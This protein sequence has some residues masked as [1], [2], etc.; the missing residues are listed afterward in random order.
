MRRQILLK[1]TKQGKELRRFD[2][3]TSLGFELSEGEMSCQKSG[4]GERM[5]VGMIMESLQSTSMWSGPAQ[6]SEGY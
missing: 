3:E 6:R 2:S 4:S 1:H 5:F